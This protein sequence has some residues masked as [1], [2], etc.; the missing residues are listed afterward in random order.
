VRRDSEL[1]SKTQQAFDQARRCREGI[2]AGFE[3]VS[4]RYLIIVSED[5]YVMPPVRE[6]AGV[7]YEYRNIAVAPST[8]SL[9]ATVH[10]K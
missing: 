9:H 4:P 1:E 7:K 2:L 3:V 6:E 8:P 5:H 10:P